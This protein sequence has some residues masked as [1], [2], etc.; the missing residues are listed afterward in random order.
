MPYEYLFIII[1]NLLKIIR[2]ARLE[3]LKHRLGVQLS[4][5][6]ASLGIMGAK[7]TVTTP[8]HHGSMESRG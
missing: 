6:L 2:K 5:R 4:E 1:F 7:F 3:I 8:E